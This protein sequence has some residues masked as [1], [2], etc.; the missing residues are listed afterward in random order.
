MRPAM[1]FEFIGG[2]GLSAVGD[3]YGSNSNLSRTR[4]LILRRVFGLGSAAGAT[5]VSNAS[6]VSGL[7][8]MQT[9]DR[10]SVTQKRR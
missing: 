6:G 1:T 10:G 4:R 2:G 7:E 8:A 5:G 9:K 3:A